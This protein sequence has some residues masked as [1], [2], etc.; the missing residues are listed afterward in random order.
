MA[1]AGGKEEW[2]M[3]ITAEIKTHKCVK[4]LNIKSTKYQDAVVC[5]CLD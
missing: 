5:M 3:D 2:K 4:L 1:L